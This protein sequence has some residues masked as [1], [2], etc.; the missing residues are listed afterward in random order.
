VHLVSA[1][2]EGI[3]AQDVVVVDLEGNLLSGGQEGTTEALL[4]ASHFEFKQRVEKKFQDNIVKM[5]EDALGE[6][7]VIARVNA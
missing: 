3:A 4:T 7:K 6:G 1:S 5:L 2:V